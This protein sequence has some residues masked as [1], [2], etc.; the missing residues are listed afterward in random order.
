MP[1]RNRVAPTGD[2]IAVPER[3]TFTGN[4]GVL[5]AEGGRIV[6]RSQVRRWIICVLEFRGRHRTVMAPRRYT[7]LFFLD[8]AT[9]L[10]AGHRPCAECRYA[11]ERRFRA[12]WAAGRGE[13]AMPRVG[14]VD[15]VLHAERAL[16]AGLRSTVPMDAAGLPDGAVVLAAGGAGDGSGTG[17]GPE[18]VVGGSLLRWTPGGYRERRPL[19]AG[20]LPVLTPP[21]TVAALRAGYRPA[22]HPTAYS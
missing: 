22:L 6:R 2:L 13:P 15:D 11:D 5:H 18:L 17:R 12:C 1:Y 19:P 8:E 14:A 3:G 7:H 20:E 9:A 16:V 10:A 21:S 4:R